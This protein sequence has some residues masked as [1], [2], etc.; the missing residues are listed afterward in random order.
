[1][2]N[3]LYSILKQ[4][5]LNA[6]SL[7]WPLLVCAFL[8]LQ[9]CASK[10]SQHQDQRSNSWPFY[11][12][13]YITH[14]NLSSR[15]TLSPLAEHQ[16]FSD[17]SESFTLRPFYRYTYDPLQK[18]VEH[19][20]FYPFGRYRK[21][22]HSGSSQDVRKELLWLLP[23]FYYSYFS[24]LPGEEEYDYFVAFPLIAGGNSYQEGAHFSLFPLA[25]NVKGLLGQD[26]ISYLLAPLY[27]EL[28]RGQNTTWYFP[29]PFL[30]YGSG[31][32]YSAFAIWPLYGTS[33]RQHKWK[34]K[35]VLWPMISWG[36][37]NLDQAHPQHYW[38][39]LPF[40]GRVW[41]DQTE[42]ISLLWPFFNYIEAESTNT[43]IIDAPWP[44]F[45]WAEGDRYSEF[46]LWPFFSQTRID[47]DR[48]YEV[49]WPFIWYFDDDES[50]FNEKRFWILP[51]FTSRYREYKAD[52]D[53]E[54]LSEVDVQGWPLFRYQR[55]TD[56]R[57][58]FTLPAL[59]PHFDQ[60]FDKLYG[61]LFDLLRIEGGP[62]EFSF[63][64][65][66]GLLNYYDQTWQSG[67]AFHPFVRYQYDKYVD[68]L[69]AR[70]GDHPKDQAEFDLL[71]GL[72]GFKEN[73]NE[74]IL[75]LLWGL[76][77]IP[78]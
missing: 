10:P 59:F 65:L 36:T 57:W 12:D 2:R 17:G 56:Q 25:G 48:S 62:D 67:W 75:K 5:H 7:L 66:W 15:K 74:S 4:K 18:E 37:N 9:A 40:I 24:P 73:E 13:E 61:E 45:R 54:N 46:R 71:Y 21:Q 72:L 11:D 60:H 22:Y 35:S 6:Y 23:F 27:L 58:S 50:H 53:Q 38:T 63:E 26:E 68:P 44:F 28:K 64:L 55:A 32:D 70:L 78:F 42:N 14:E 49:L 20:A 31:P 41:S 47:D 19:L 51:F 34:R 77:E 69:E 30:K 8:L 1:M 43:T 3:T 76:I 39:F 33:S 16:H 29:F 52:F